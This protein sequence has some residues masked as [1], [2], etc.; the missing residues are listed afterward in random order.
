MKK[1]KTK[2][3]IH[4]SET[5]PPGK[6]IEKLMWAYTRPGTN[7]SITTTN[8]NTFLVRTSQYP[9]PFHIQL[10]EVRDLAPVELEVI[11]E[12]RSAAWKRQIREEI[13]RRAKQEVRI[14]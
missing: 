2:V 1:P 8:N 12:Q 4:Y 7:L 3:T 11:G 6:Y 13:R 5:P 9:H 14:P 10:H